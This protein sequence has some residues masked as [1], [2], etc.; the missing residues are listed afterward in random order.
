MTPH[1]HFT[2]RPRNALYGV[3]DDLLAV[4][5][6]SQQLLDAG[7]G[8][9]QVQVLTGEEGIRDL[10][11]DGRHHG[12]VSRL[13]RALQSITDE[14]DHIEH[15]VGELLQ[16]RHV[17]AVGVPGDPQSVQQLCAMF[18]DCGGHYIHHYGP[19]VVQELGA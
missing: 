6:L 14:R 9:R 8:E 7:F 18:K 12:L 13:L 15:Y 1:G 5:D 2:F 11:P 19:Y 4:R 3:F 16:G 10:D 17:V